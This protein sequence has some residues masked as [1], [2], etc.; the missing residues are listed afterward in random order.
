MKLY[1]V[2]VEFTKKE[3][4]LF[5]RFV[6]FLSPACNAEDAIRIVRE[7]FDLPIDAKYS[8]TEIDYAR[9]PIAVQ[10]AGNIFAVNR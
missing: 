5:M 4:P 3:Q 7:Q 1:H 9:P 2:D 10:I 6:R 8:T